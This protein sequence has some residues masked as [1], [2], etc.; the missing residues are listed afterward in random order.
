VTATVKTEIPRPAV[1]GTGTS[2]CTQEWTPPP[3]SSRRQDATGVPLDVTSSLAALL[4]LESLREELRVSMAG[5]VET[6]A[7]GRMPGMLASPSAGL[8]QASPRVSVLA[9]ST[10]FGSHPTNES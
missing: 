7:A 5:A 10:V 4:F 3:S 2:K 8:G 9:T 1:A 6:L